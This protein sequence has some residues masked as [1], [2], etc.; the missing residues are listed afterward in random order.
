MICHE[1]S[2]D[3]HQAPNGHT[4]E[5]DEDQPILRRLDRQ[6]QRQSVAL[7]IPRDQRNKLKDQPRLERI[8]ERICVAVSAVSEVVLRLG[9]REVVEELAAEVPQ[10]IDGAFI[11]AANEP[12]ELGKDQCEGVQVRTVRWQVEDSRTN[13]FADAGNLVRG[14]VVHHHEVSLRQRGGEMIS[15]RGQEHLT[16]DRT[17]GCGQPRRATCREER[18]RL[19]MTVRDFGNQPFAATHSPPRSRHV[20]FAPR[21]VEKHEPLEV[22]SGLSESEFG[23]A[24]GHIGAILF[25]RMKDFFETVLQRPQCHRQSLQAERDA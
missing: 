17:I 5:S 9:W 11:R 24:S 6:R 22:E 25:G 16:V 18:G 10:I 20:R 4:D 13:G 7:R 1:F 19:P 12:L 2:E 21:F 15:H 8:T 14:Q 23:T 3:H